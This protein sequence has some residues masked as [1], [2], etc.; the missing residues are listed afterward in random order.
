VDSSH[1]EKQRRGGDLFIVD[2]SDEKWKVVRY[3]QEWADIAHTFD[4]ATG[5]FEIGAFL[6][7]T[8]YGLNTQTTY[9][10]K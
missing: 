2:N 5:F 1:E 9:G 4:I 10:M 6:V 8:C 7:W 3:L